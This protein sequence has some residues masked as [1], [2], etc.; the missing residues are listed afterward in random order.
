MVAEVAS[1]FHFRKDHRGAGGVMLVWGDP[2]EPYGDRH[3][4]DA[5]WLESVRALAAHRLP[6]LRDVPIDPARCW[7]GLYAV[8]PDHRPL[9]GP[10]PGVRGLYCAAGFS[11][12]GVMHAPAT[13]QLLAEWIL[14][15]APRLCDGT[16]FAP[17]RFA[18]RNIPWLPPP[19]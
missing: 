16:P 8:T 14:E 10:L 6:A 5:R 7:T 3:E 12:H 9:L 2:D 1:G 15:G 11:G 18:R 13:G 4:F 19:F 17:D